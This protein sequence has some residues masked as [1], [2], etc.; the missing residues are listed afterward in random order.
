M[1]HHGAQ[2]GFPAYNTAIL[3]GKFVFR[4]VLLIRFDRQC[5]CGIVLMDV[6]VT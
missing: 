6:I 4:P 5:A 1:T 3:I 2:V